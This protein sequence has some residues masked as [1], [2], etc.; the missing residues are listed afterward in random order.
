GKQHIGGVQRKVLA[1]F[2]S[3]FRKITED[4]AIENSAEQSR[5]YSIPQ[6]SHKHIGCGRNTALFPTNCPL[7]K[8]NKRGACK[9]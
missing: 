6:V 7:Y 4:L 5:T 9:P 1:C 3:M 8:H 2:A